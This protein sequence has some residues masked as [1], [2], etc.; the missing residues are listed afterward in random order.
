MNKEYNVELQK[1]YLEM[2]VSNPEAFVRVQNIFNPQNFDRSLRPIAT[3]VLN[4]VDQY[5]T[6]PEVNQI[7][8]KTGSKLQDVVT[9]QLEEHSNWLLDEFEQFSRHKELERAILDSA[10]LL[11]KGD[12]GLVEAKIKDAVQVGL[13]KDMGTDYWDNPRE[14]LMTLKTSNGQVST[15]GKCLIENCLVDLIEVSYKYLQVVVVVV[16]VCLCKI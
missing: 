1:L 7:N 15:V 10:D 8:S 13:T 5:K 11:E 14:R 4:Y 16:K 6:L 12:Y 2:L 9:E 3:F